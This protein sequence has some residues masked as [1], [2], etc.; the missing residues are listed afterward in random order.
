MEPLCKKA[1]DPYLRPFV[2]KKRKMAKPVLTK[3]FLQSAKPAAMCKASHD[4]TRPPSPIPPSLLAQ[5]LSSKWTVPTVAKI[6]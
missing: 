3:A 5:N 2:S 1:E 6:A 4:E